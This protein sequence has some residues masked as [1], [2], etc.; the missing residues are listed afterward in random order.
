MR[1]DHLARSWVLV[2][3]ASTAVAADPYADRVI[4][5]APGVGANP[6]YQVPEVAIGSPERF[7]GEG[8]FPSV[9]T[10]FNPAFGADE[11]V[12]LG[13]GGSLT[14]GFDEPIVDDPSN[15]FGVDFLVFGNSFLVDGDYPNGITIG[16]FAAPRDAR[17]EVSA[18]GMVWTPAR[19]VA[20]LGLY[21]ALG[22]SDVTDPY[23]ISKGAVNSDFTRPVDPAFDPVG[24]TFDELRAGYA[25]SGGGMGF[26]LSGTGLSAVRFVRVIN[27]RGSI[28]IDAISDAAPVPTPGVPLTLGCA[29][30]LLARRRRPAG[31]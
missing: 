14:L 7:T 22:Y 6:A 15:P 12:A 3:A 8:V 29:G 19:R 5:Y 23:A 27:D 9:V 20:A 28:S 1:F 24:K 13:A 17:V 18:D 26:D 4:G 30:A 10:P 2:L 31:R 21:P 11:I 25:G 16:V